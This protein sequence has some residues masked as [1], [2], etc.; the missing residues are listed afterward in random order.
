MADG[1]LPSSLDSDWPEGTLFRW[2]GFLP[3]NQ[4]LY[5]RKW[6][7]FTKIEYGVANLLDARNQ[8]P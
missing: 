7:A 8:T 5:S 2:D 3:A 1:S 4:R 6:S